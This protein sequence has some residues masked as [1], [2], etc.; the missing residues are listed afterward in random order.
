MIAITTALLRMK[1]SSEPMA[2][3]A[4]GVHY[5]DWLYYWQHFE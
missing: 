5:D 2:D 3:E 4:G 1:S